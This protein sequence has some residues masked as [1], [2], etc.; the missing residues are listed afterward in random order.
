M[1]CKGLGSAVLSLFGPEVVSFFQMSEGLLTFLSPRCKSLGS[2]LVV[3]VRLVNAESDHVD[4]PITVLNS[5]TNSMGKGFRTTA[6]VTLSPPYL[7]QLEDLLYAFAVRPDLGEMGRR[8]P[9]QRVSLTT[10]SQEIPGQQG[11]TVDISS[12]GL[13]LRCAAPVELGT[14][15]ALELQTDMGGLPSISAR[16]RVLSCS[17][18][19]DGLAYEVGIDFIGSSPAQVAIVDYYLQTLASRTPIAV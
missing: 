10:A 19:A 12:H 13:R 9:R 16:G 17:D 18:S 3:R 6:S 8:S 4:I 14:P 7:A 15:L 5:R 2:K 11:M 1:D